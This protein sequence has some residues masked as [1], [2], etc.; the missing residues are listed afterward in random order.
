MRGGDVVALAWIVGKVEE[1]R[2]VVLCAAVHRRRR[3]RW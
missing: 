2:R 3:R 1:E